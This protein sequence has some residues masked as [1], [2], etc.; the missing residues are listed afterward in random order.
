MIEYWITE[1]LDW[2]NYQDPVNWSNTTLAGTVNL[3]AI[4]NASLYSVHL[5]GYN[6]EDFN[7]YTLPNPT[8]HVS[9]EYFDA[10][11]WDNIHGLLVE[12]N[13]SV[14]VGRGDDTYTSLVFH[15]LIIT[16]KTTD[17]VPTNLTPITVTPNIINTLTATIENQGV[18][19]STAFN[20]SLL[21]DGTIVDTQSVASLAAGSSTTVDFHWTPGTANGYTVTVS[22]DPENAIVENDDGN[23]FLEVLV[24]NNYSTC[25]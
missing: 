7:G 1:G 21:V 23:N 12:E 24:G 4:Q 14:N 25:T 18:E 8:E 10:L 2:L 22:V 11:R 13:Q 5:T 17:L 15:A 3:T 20:V 6:Y 9:G 16:Y 19:D